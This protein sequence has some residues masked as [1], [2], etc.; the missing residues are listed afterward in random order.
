MPSVF[1]TYFGNQV[2]E[3]QLRATSRYLALF[4][5][6][7]GVLG[8][9][10]DEVA[11]GDYERQLLPLTAAGSK[12]TGNSGVIIFDNLPACTVT[13]MAIADLQ[14]AG[15]L[16]LITQ[17]ASPLVIPNSARLT[18]AAGEVAVTL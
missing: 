5:A 14:F 11:G 16:L 10:A 8:S 7:P 15:H 4:T 9:L 6:D 1:T 17:T 18:L 12:T 2:I 3:Q 13:Y